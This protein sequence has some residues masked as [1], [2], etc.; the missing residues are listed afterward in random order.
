MKIEIKTPEQITPENLQAT[1]NALSAIQNKRVA[2]A[3]I[4][5]QVCIWGDA[6]KTADW[7]SVEFTIETLE[8][9]RVYVGSPYHGIVAQGNIE[10]G[11][12]WWIPCWS[13]DDFGKNFTHG[14][15]WSAPSVRKLPREKGFE[16]LKAAIMAKPTDF[17]DYTIRNKRAE[18][19][20]N[21]QWLC[22]YFKI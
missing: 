16:T 15:T 6:T 9:S 2:G 12:I 21:R 14:G 8:L 4:E 10:D 11:E 13:H 22:E 17:T 3:V 18:A 1:I 5:G 19:I 7:M 20:R